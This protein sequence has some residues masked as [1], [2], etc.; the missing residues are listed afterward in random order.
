MNQ[1]ERCHFIPAALRKIKIVA[2]VCILAI[3]S[4]GGLAFA[5]NFEPMLTLGQTAG[6]TELQQRSGDAVQ[7]VCGGFLSDTGGIDASR[8][9]VAQQTI[10]FDKCGEMVQTANVLAGADQGAPGTQKSLGITADEL[11]AAVQNV[12]AEEIAA[13]GSLA[14][15]SAARQSTTVGRRL[16]SLLSRVS[17]LQL[18]SA[19][20]QSAGELIAVDK[21]ASIFNTGGAAAADDALASP[22]GFYV[23]ALG[24]TTDKK[25][26]EGEDGFEASSAGISVGFDYLVTS[27]LLAGVNIG[28]TSAT[29]DFD[30]TID[31]DGGELE[32]NQINLSG[33]GMWFNDSAYVDMIAGFSSGS[34]DMTRRIVINSAD[35]AMDTTSDDG[36]QPNDGANDTV[37]ADT[38]SSAFRFGVGAGYEF[39]SGGLSFAPYGR[40]SVLSVEL[41][42]YQETGESA[43]TLRVDKQDIESLTGAAGFRLTKTFSGS[44]AVI[45]PQLSVEI[46]H[47]FDDD[48]RQIV[49]SYVHDPR[50]LPLIVVTDSPDRDYYTIGAGVS[51][52]LQGGTQ[53]FTEIRSLQSLDDLN[54][55][56]FAAGVRFE[57]R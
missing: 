15:E 48:S 46:V 28:Y 55:L 51:A 17:P 35:G 7:M 9:D 12:T 38:D 49:S 32:T 44:K 34:F 42:A 30:T 8:D 24:A 53:L 6:F 4:S 37:F 57:F 11:G 56:S 5:Q 19:N 41:D 20:I 13:A 25:T 40:V 18:S 22:F 1:V 36:P 27:T 29:T 21:P 33:Y 54:E 50:N 23:N 2:S 26:T 47:E 14:T 10:L 16:S 3:I 52:V 31:V 45:S 43:L 39:R